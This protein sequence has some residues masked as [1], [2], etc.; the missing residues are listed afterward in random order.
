[1]F[2]KAKEG[3]PNDGKGE[4]DACYNVKLVC[5]LP[6]LAS[7]EGD[8]VRVGGDDLSLTVL[9]RRKPD[10]G[11]EVKHSQMRE[12]RCRDTNRPLSFAETS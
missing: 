6:V 9:V 10:G 2:D 12:G 4:V 8:L 1:M 3:P 11:G 7:E 5:R